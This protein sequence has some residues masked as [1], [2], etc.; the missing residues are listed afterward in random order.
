MIW[1]LTLSEH[2]NFGSL[3]GEVNYHYLV[4]SDMP[5]VFG[6]IAL[7]CQRGSP[8]PSQDTLGTLYLQLS[9]SEMKINLLQ[10]DSVTHS[11]CFACFHLKQGFQFSDV[12]Y[13]LK[14]TWFH[15]CHHQQLV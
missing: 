2:S 8:L 9:F 12:F 7:R 10:I 6:A 14:L 13:I 1:V 15:Y 11:S 5:R 4:S 3:R